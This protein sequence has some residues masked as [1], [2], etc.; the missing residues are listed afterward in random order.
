MLG[1]SKTWLL[2][3]IG[4]F[5]MQYAGTVQ[6]AVQTAVAAL[7]SGMF[8]ALMTWTRN[9]AVKEGTIAN[10][11]TGVKT[12][13]IIENEFYS[14]KPGLKDRA[15]KLLILLAPMLLPLLYLSAC[16]GMRF[17]HVLVLETGQGTEEPTS[18]VVGA[19]ADDPAPPAILQQVHETTTTTT[20]TTPEV[21]THEQVTKSSVPRDFP[22]AKWK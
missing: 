20:E 11:V 8:A 19:K 16:G 14:Q 18:L 7:I 2:A 17:N 10:P 21:Q 12:E 13:P 5:L 1:L 3:L 22:A 4:S 9:Q 15:D 6:T